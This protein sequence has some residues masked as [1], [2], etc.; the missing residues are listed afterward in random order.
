M[1]SKPMAAPA[2]TPSAWIVTNNRKDKS[3]AS[4]KGRKSV[5]NGKVYLDDGDEFEIELHNPLTE[6]VLCDIKLNGQ[7]IS[8]N[9]LVLKP[10]QRFYLDCFIDDKKK[11]IF[12]TYEIEDTVESA[13]ATAKNG[14]LEVYFYKE[15]VVQI[16]DWRRRFDQVIVREY[17]P[18]YYPYYHPYY[19]PYYQPAIFSYGCTT[20]G[21]AIGINN[22]TLTSTNLSGLNSLNSFGSA[23]TSA[24][25]KEKSK[26]LFDDY[27]SNLNCTGC[28]GGDSYI[29]SPNQQMYTAQASANVETGRVEKGVASAQ[30]FTEI[31][32]QFQSMY[33]AHTVLQLLPN[34][35]KPAETKDIVKKEVKDKLNASDILRR[36]S[37]EVIELIKKLNDLYKAGILTDDE[38]NTKKVELLSKI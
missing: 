29:D 31:D 33:I 19:H 6:C 36:E 23:G 17:Y 24:D 35:R 37:D 13:D 9:G 30:K 27:S 14:L 12:N 5:K 21:G 38:F 26:S 11:F 10:G 8:K 18:V 34:S 20:A 22:C 7:S 16:N 4:D 2:S 3:Q 1:G 25:A 15:D 32:M 28:F